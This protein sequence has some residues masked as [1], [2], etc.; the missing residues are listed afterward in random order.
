MRVN[1]TIPDEWLPILK[2]AAK[3]KKTSLS[4]LLYE[5]AAATLPEREQRKLPV[6]REPGAPLKNGTA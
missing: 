3:R 1:V 5:S 4:R 6:P 2:N